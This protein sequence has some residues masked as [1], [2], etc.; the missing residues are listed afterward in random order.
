MNN[1]V[2]IAHQLPWE[3]LED[4]IAKRAGRY[5]VDL[6][7]D[8]RRIRKTAKPNTIEAAREL[9]AEI[10]YEHRK[11]NA[12]RSAKSIFRA[13]NHDWSAAVAEM[14]QRGQVKKKFLDLRTSARKRNIDFSL[15]ED[16]V[17]DLILQCNGKC[18]LTGIALEFGTCTRHPFK[19]SM[20]R[21]DPK[22]GY[23]YDNMRVVCFCV[24]VA[25]GEW[26]E[27]VLAAIALGFSRQLLN[28][29]EDEIARK[30]KVD[31]YFAT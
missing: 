23:R 10:F 5:T 13:V 18:S 21:I 26:G 29:L 14:C 17:R 30:L 12:E 1:R 31:T 28:N 24:N 19:L 11:A 6:I 22:S 2:G 25:I 7:I 8:G 20:D 16:Q 15:T 27:E 4:G 9:R 3:R